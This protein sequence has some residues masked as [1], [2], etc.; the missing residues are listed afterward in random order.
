MQ[1]ILAKKI[2]GV[3]SEAD[4]VTVKAGYG[5]NYLIPQGLAFEATSSNTR[6]INKLKATRAEREA[7]EKVSAEELANKINATKIELTLESG[8]GGKAFGA[9]TNQSLHD[10]L[11]A[12]GIELDRRMIDL[13]KPIKSSGAH[14]VIVK[15]HPEVTATLKVIVTITGE[16]AQEEV[17]AEA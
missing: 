1:V 5:R 13:D 6:F 16:K 4:L 12:K 14:D 7:A 15:L 3:G 10:A 17:P 9:V 11:T 2:E 8:Q